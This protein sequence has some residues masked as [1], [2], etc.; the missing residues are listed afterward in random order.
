MRVRLGCALVVIWS[1]AAPAGAAVY[2][3]T[4]L[5]PDA[6]LSRARAIDGGVQ[7]GVTTQPPRGQTGLAATWAGT[8]ESVAYHTTG[9]GSS[10]VYDILGDRMV[11]TVSGSQGYR[12]IQWRNGEPFENE[13][14]PG[15]S[16]T[17]S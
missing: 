16:Q 15:Y 7:G 9:F 8:P 5:M 14:P 1:C 10:E 6:E 2:R 11:G 17:W 3:A 4:L 12:A 13:L